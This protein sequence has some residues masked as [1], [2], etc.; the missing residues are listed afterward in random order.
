MGVLVGQPFAGVLHGLYWWPPRLRVRGDGLT[1]LSAGRNGAADRH[2]QVRRQPALWFDG[3]ESAA[4]RAEKWRRFCTNRSTSLEE[5]ACPGPSDRRREA[6]R[7]AVFLDPP[8]ESTEVCAAD[9]SGER[10]TVL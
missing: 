9:P 8:Y 10:N 4:R 3:S 5:S 7:C 1:E 2:V 6:D